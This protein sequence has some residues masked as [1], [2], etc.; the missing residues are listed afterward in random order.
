MALFQLQLSTR[1][2]GGDQ[3]RA[4]GGGRW[5]LLL[6]NS[7]CIPTHEGRDQRDLGIL[8][9]LSQDRGIRT[10]RH[11]RNRPRGVGED[12]VRSFQNHIRPAASGLLLGGPR[13]HAVEPAGS[14]RRHPISF[15]HFLWQRRAEAG[16]RGVYR[17]TRESQGL[18]APGRDPGSSIEGFLSSRGLPPG[19]CRTPSEQPIHRVQRCAESCSSSRAVSGPLHGQVEPEEEVAMFDSDLGANEKSVVRRRAFLVT[20]TSALAGAILW[21]LRRPR[22]VQAEAAKGASQGTSEEVTIV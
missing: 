6:G 3:R 17:T 1:P 11:R 15:V 4:D 14:G 20:T 12:Y 2:W 16:R 7:G 8:R 9:R 10:G 22:L 18:S 19:L 21:S 5:W 13:P